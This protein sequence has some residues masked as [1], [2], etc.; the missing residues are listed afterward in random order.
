MIPDVPHFKVTLRG[1]SCC[2]YT[3]E[4]GFEIMEG[5]NMLLQIDHWDDSAH[6]K[7]DLDSLTANEIIKFEQRTDFEAFHTQ[8]KTYTL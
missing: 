4:D 1:E 5:A 6:Y 7:F 2:L 8:H 3:H